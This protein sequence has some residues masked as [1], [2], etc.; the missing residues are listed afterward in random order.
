[1]VSSVKPFTLMLGKIVGVA[2]CRFTS[3]V[4]LGRD[5]FHYNDSAWSLVGCA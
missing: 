1:M 2:L 4:Y 3:N 5:A